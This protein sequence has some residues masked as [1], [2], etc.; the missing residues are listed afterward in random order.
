MTGVVAD[1]PL[2]IGASIRVKDCSQSHGAAVGHWRS[3]GL[4]AALWPLHHEE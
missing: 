3:E 4:Y 1:I 2:G